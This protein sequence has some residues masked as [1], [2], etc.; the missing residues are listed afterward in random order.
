MATLH[1]RTGVQFAFPADSLNGSI[2]YLPS[3]A[4]LVMMALYCRHTGRPCSGALLAAT[5][6]FTLSLLLRT[7]DSALCP[8]WPLGIHFAW[9]LS[10]SLMLYL[11][12]TVVVP[13]SPRSAQARGRPAA[14]AVRSVP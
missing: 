2:F 14:S 8:V 5:L 7:L 12:A 6:L 9:H 3:W 1:F 11:A 13:P 4:T 10:N